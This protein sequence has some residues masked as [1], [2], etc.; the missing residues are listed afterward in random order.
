MELEIAPEKVAHVIIKAREYDV[1]VGS[2][3]T[4]SERRRRQRGPRG[5][6]RSPGGNDPT[7]ARTRRLHQRLKR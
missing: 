1:K 5:D 7:R 6:P 2:W 3:S 4:T